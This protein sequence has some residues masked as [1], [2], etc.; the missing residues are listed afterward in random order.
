MGHEGRRGHRAAWRGTHREKTAVGAMP[1][2]VPGST[3]SEAATEA[4]PTGS[5]GRRLCWHR[6]PCIPGL[7]P[8]ERVNHAACGSLLEQPLAADSVTAR[9]EGDG[10]VSAAVAGVA[11]AGGG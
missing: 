5:G 11:G 7:Q 6:G 3:G 2:G 10:V 4:V 9:A 1:G 8:P